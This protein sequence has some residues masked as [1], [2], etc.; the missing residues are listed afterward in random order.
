ME[1]RRFSGAAAPATLHGKHRSSLVSASVL[2]ALQ[3]SVC[4]TIASAWGGRGGMQ[5][6]GE[7]GSAR[8]GRQVETLCAHTSFCALL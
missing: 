8:G 3:R 6:V 7:K 5:E 1:A 4:S 2:T